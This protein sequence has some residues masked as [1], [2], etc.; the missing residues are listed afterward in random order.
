MADD[1]LL[2]VDVHSSSLVHV[3]LQQVESFL[4]FNEILR[5]LG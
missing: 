3:G 1:H 4:K 5:N 2:S